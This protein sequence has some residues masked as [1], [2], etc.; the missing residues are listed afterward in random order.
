MER[1][2]FLERGKVRR[3]VELGAESQDSRARDEF[4]TYCQ[5]LLLTVRARRGS[6]DWECVR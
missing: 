6:K 3:N 4:V 1:V 5:V 2:V